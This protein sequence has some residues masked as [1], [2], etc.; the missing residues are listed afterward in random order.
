[1]IETQLE[2]MTQRFWGRE[3]FAMALGAAGYSDIR[4]T[5]DYARTR[6]PRRGDRTLTF[7]ATRV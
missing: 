1:L 7:E 6:A 5:G 4:V 3:E 2:P